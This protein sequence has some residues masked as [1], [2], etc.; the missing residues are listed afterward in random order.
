M[1][2]KNFGEE[3]IDPEEDAAALA[4]AMG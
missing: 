1:T 4:E 3:I 2:D